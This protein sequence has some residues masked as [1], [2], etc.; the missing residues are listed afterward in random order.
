MCVRWYVNYS[1]WNTG[2]PVTGECVRVRFTDCGAPNAHSVTARPRRVRDVGSNRRRERER[3]EEEKKGRERITSSS[4]LRSPRDAPVWSISREPI[5]WNLPREIGVLV[6][7][8][9]VASGVLFSSDSIVRRY[10]RIASTM[11]DVWFNDV[12]RYF[13]D[14]DHSYL[15]DTLCFEESSE[16]DSPR[17]YSVVY[18]ASACDFRGDENRCLNSKLRIARNS[19]CT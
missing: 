8:R 9:V 17:R 5:Y 15:R 7:Q 18:E 13:H 14:R 11:R 2:G 4:S 1:Q 16:S 3:E 12:A 19:R 6:T 10:A